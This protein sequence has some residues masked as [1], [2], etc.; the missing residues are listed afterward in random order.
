MKKIRFVVF[1]LRCVLQNKILLLGWALLVLSIGMLVTHAAPTSVTQATHTAIG[2]SMT[3]VGTC[4]LLGT[5]LGYSTI[6]TYYHTRKKLRQGQSAEVQED[7]RSYIYCNKIGAKMAVADA[8]K[9]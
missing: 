2:L 5:R 8:C 9:Q 6:K 4:C 1:Y 7:K 3:I